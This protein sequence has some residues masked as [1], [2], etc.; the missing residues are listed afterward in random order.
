MTGSAAGA[1]L[2]R[3]LAP[4]C[5]WPIVACS[6]GGLPPASGAVGGVEPTSVVS[7]ERSAQPT[8]SSAPAARTPT[9]PSA[10]REGTVAA[11]ARVR[12]TPQSIE[13]PNGDSAVVEPV[14]TVGGVL[15]VPAD[16]DH[17]GWWDGS[18]DAGDPFGATVIAGHVDSARQGL[19]V[20]A[21][22]LLVRS[23]DL[24]TLR[25]GPDAM[26][27]RV[28]SS[29]LVR[30]DALASDGEAFDQRGPHR[31]VLITCSGQ[32]HPEIRSYDSNL[33]VVA[34]PTAS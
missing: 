21:Q 15:Q 31:L 13:L 14:P 18:A 4:L 3:A 22:L 9:Q 12:F 16:V 34:E 23:G 7:A 27:Y 6:A 20:F 19:G 10:I 33:V 5:V 17:V 29:V 8:I 24:V 32:W 25:S 28:V 11:S 26:S 2:R 1:R 30:K